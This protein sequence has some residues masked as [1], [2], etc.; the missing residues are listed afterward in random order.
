MKTLEISNENIRSNAW[1]DARSAA[2]SA[3][4]SAARSDACAAYAVANKSQTT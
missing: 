4:R 1:T 2:Q 3:A